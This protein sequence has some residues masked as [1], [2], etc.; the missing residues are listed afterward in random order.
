MRLVSIISGG[1]IDGFVKP[2]I[3]HFC[4]SKDTESKNAKVDEKITAA[5]PRP[6][7]EVKQQIPAFIASG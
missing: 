7:G 1:R 4:P 2:G 6:P 5:A 3:L